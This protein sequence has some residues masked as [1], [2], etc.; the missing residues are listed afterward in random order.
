MAGQ[1]QSDNTEGGRFRPHRLAL[2]AALTVLIGWAAAMLW[3]L[4]D[5]A[6]PDTAS[7][8]V[9]AVF[10]PRMDGEAIL[11]A[12]VRA[13]GRPLRP[14]WPGNVWVVNGAEA[15]FVRRLRARGAVAAYGEMPM[16]P[17][18]AGCFAYVDSQLPAARLIP[19]P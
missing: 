9:L 1:Q 12:V 14:L 10:Q 7:G 4:R 17:V 11:A 13:G 2:A 18:L 16:G 5:A 15:G 3:V 6:L 19:K 8:T